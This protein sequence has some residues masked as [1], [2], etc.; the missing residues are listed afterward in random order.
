MNKSR[1]ENIEYD[2]IKEGVLPEQFL[3]ETVFTPNPHSSL[4]DSKW[5][6]LC[7]DERHNIVQI[8][9]CGESTGNLFNIFANKATPQT[10][11]N[12]I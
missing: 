4:N 7:G 8:E 12:G 9:E 10:E 6:L 3:K 5:K 1:N 2:R 11:G